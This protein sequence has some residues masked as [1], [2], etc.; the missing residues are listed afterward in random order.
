MLRVCIDPCFGKIDNKP[1]GILAALES[2]GQATDR[3]RMSLA[4]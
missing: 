2:V 4:M 3:V 1:L